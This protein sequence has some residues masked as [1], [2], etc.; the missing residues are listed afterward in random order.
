MNKK[1]E[2][3]NNNYF[4]NINLP[5]LI[6][7]ASQTEEF[8]LKLINTDRENKLIKKIE[9]TIKKIKDGKF[10]YCEYCYNKINIKR[11]KIQPIAKLCIDCKKISENLIN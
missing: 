9:N 3:L 10:G 11:L 1:R 8:N 7:K 5:D 6:D 4:K 2:N